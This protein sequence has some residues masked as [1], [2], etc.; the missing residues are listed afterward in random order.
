MAGSTSMEVQ[1]RQPQRQARGMLPERHTLHLPTNL[2]LLRLILL[3][4]GARLKKDHRTNSDGT[5]H[6]GRCQTTDQTRSQLRT[7]TLH[8]PAPVIRLSLLILRMVIMGL[9]T[10]LRMLL[11]SPNNLQITTPRHRKSILLMGNQRHHTHLQKR[12]TPENHPR[13]TNPLL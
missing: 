9:P 1:Q 11:L 7:P 3:N 8:K 2:N 4:H 12:R 6:D 5:S 10:H 13:A